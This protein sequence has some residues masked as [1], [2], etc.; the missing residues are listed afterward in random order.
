MEKRIGLLLI[1]LSFL[2]TAYVSVLDT[3]TVD[4]RWFA[5]A[6]VVGAIGIVMVQMG[7]RKLAGETD[8][9][10]ADLTVIEESLA[11]LVN[12][13]ADLDEKKGEIH[14]Y[15]MRHKIDELLLDDLDRFANAR[16]SISH[17]YGLQA[18]ADVMSHFAG[19]ERY[20][21]RVWSASADGYIDEV[22]AYLTKAH[23]QFEIASARL[24]EFRSD[25]P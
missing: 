13:V 3:V 17:A 4:W 2:A 5:P 6:F 18:Y 9:I 16:E 11:N 12:M 7:K 25:V 10:A 21:N 8:R 20:L 24:A 1:A 15:D 22:N 14:T 19:G 23:E